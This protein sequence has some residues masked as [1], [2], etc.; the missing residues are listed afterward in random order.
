MHHRFAVPIRIATAVAL[1]LAFA[2]PAHAQGKTNPADARG[3]KM[4]VA[5]KGKTAPD[6]VMTGID[7]K[8][9]KL[10]DRTG[11]EKHIVLMFSRASW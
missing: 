6:F 5:E 11:K 3:K 2:F 9:F 7:G 1:L 4:A 10:S 8:E